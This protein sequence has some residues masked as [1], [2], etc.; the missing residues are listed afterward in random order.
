MSLPVTLPDGVVTF[1]FTDVEG[2]TKLL[3]RDLAAADRAL[4]RH[5]ELVRAAVESNAGAV[6]ETVGD[7]VYAAFA[8]PTAAIEAALA[9]QAALAR[10]DWRD[11]GELKIRIAVHTGTV[12]RREGHYFGRSLFVAARL[13]SLAHGGQSLVSAA[14]AAIVAGDL[15]KERRLVALGRHLLK[16]L[17]ERIDV[18][19][20]E[21]PGL[22][23]TFPPLRSR[24]HSNLPESLTSFVGRADLV[25]SIGAL[26]SDHRLVTLVGPGGIGKTR[27]A[28]EVGSVVADR[29]PHGVWWVPLSDHRDPEAVLP[30]IAGVVGA[31]GDLESFLADWDA[32]LVVDNLEQVIDGAADLARLVRACPRIRMIATSR[33]QLHVSGER[34]VQVQALSREDGLELVRQRVGEARPG[35][36]VDEETAT[37]LW[38]VLDGLPL[39]IELAAAR[40]RAIDPADLVERLEHRLGVLVDGPRD[41]PDRQR[42]LRAAIAWSYDLLDEEDR[43]AFERLAVFD[44]GWTIA[45]G[46]AICGVDI[47]TT[48]RLLDRNLIQ[49]IGARL[50]MLATIKEFADE[51]RRGRSDR[52]VFERSHAEWFSTYAASAEHAF[53]SSIDER[54]WLDRMAADWPNLRAGMLW[55]IEQGDSEV[56]LRYLSS[57]WRYWL[58][59]GLAGEGRAL[60]EAAFALHADVPAAVRADSSNAL[61]EIARYQGDLDRAADLKAE[62]IAHLRVVGEEFWLGATLADMAWIEVGRF[63]LDEARKFAEESLA[64]RRRV[65]RSQGI[66]HALGAVGGVAIAEGDFRRAIQALEEAR[67]LTARGSAMWASVSIELG[68]AYLRA[69]QEQLAAGAIREGLAAARSID[70]RGDLV[71]TLAI[72]ADLAEASEPGFAAR[73]LA[74]SE[75]LSEVDAIAQAHPERIVALAERLTARLGRAAFDEAYSAGTSLDREEAIGEAIAWLSSISDD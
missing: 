35:A 62:A 13:M 8:S 4:V 6:F 9:A 53:S 19:Q 39:A 52:T 30:A 18:Y 24:G 70:D 46:E 50:Q 60:G 66:G 51:K 64:I 1:L 65:G 37:S 58:M 32:L 40:A 54:I 56:A 21:A 38:R 71:G 5:H 10:E 27:L 2:S 68:E 20:L 67:S 69:G 28:I 57:C 25:T 7:A 16:D 33:E 14:T 22:A 63:R 74:A 59:R 55:A 12:D 31:P 44:G 26:V 42:T 45:A 3:E 73:L 23:T 72:V 61:G 15:P 29:F 43:E 34:V 41:A 49:S 48:S 17:D 11:I 75:R 36:I 47:D